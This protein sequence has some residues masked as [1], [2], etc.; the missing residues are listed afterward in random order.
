M[1]FTELTIFV[2]ALILLTA[3]NLVFTL[4]VSKKKYSRVGVWI[5]NV[6][7]IIPGFLAVCTGLYLTIIENN[8]SLGW[9]LFSAGLLLE[10]GAVQLSRML[11]KQTNLP[12]K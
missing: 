4:S 1:E 11:D 9:A 12:N 5:M 10:T 6:T 8:S 2:F 7:A 3:N